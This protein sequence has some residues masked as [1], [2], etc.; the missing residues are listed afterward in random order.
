MRI[1]EF[2]LD[3]DG[4]FSSTRL[5]FIAWGFGVL[6]AWMSTS[7]NGGALQSLDWSIVGILASLMTGKAVQSFGEKPSA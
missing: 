1:F 6:V 2:F 4:R 3:A 7:I 5:V